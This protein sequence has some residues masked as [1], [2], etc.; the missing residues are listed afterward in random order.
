MFD[1]FEAFEEQAVPEGAIKLQYGLSVQVVQLTAEANVAAE[2]NV[3]P[4]QLAERYA[5]AFNMPTR[6]LV[7][8]ADGKEI[9]FGEPV[10]E[11]AKTI[12]FRQPS[13]EKGADQRQIWVNGPVA[14]IFP[15]RDSA[16]T[17]AIY[18]YTPAETR[19]DVVWGPK[20][21][22][23][24]ADLQI[25]S[26]LKVL[27]PVIGFEKTQIVKLGDEEVKANSTKRL[28]RKTLSIVQRIDLPQVQTL[29]SR[30][31]AE[32]FVGQTLKE[33]LASVPHPEGTEWKAWDADGEIEDKE[34]QPGDYITVAFLVAR[35]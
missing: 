34:I 12:E 21:F 7:V 2:K 4:A 3:T 24:W 31:T 8:Y 17:I 15:I 19:Y 14:D 28:G 1:G 5:Q 29:H 35:A 26:I 25:R 27:G 18:N 11:T 9:P 16:A 23:Q 20:A 22:R 13:G 32:A 10:P 33:V 30:L 6:G